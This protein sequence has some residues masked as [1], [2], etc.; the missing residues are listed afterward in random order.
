M[1]NR[2]SEEVFQRAILQ[3]F[4]WFFDCLFRRIS[5]VTKKGES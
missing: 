2:V 4:N 1:R 5:N 3:A